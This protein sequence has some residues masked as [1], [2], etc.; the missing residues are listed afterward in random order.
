[1][2]ATDFEDRYQTMLHLSVVAISFLT[3]LFD[4]DD[5][6]WAFVRHQ[7]QPRLLERVLF[8]VATLL[9]GAGAALRTWARVYSAPSMAGGRSVSRHSPYRHLR[10]PGQL[11]NLLFTTGLAFLAPLWGFVLL[12]V[13]EAIL[14]FRLIQ[15]EK[16]LHRLAPPLAATS[17]GSPSAAGSTTWGRA[18]RLESG[19]WGLFATMIV[20]T[21]LLEDRVAE[22]LAI[23]SVLLWFA[24]NHGSFRA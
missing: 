14:V 10:Y 15:R 23:A 5:I 24:L 6:V 19:K 9:I 17:E 16:A 12:I 13:G 3:Y 7:S 22:V 18:L 1:M 2:R 8:A 21:V 11:G 20:F 4:P